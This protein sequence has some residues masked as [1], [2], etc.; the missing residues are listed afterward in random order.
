MTINN[1]LSLTEAKIS[2][3]KLCLFI[4]TVLSFVINFL[5]I[6][7][8][9]RGGLGF[10]YLVLPLIICLI[11]GAFV[12]AATFTN[13]KFSYSALYTTVFSVIFGITTLISALVFLN[14]GKGTAI[15][16][17]AFILW[18]I[19]AAFSITAIIISAHRAGKSYGAVK[20]VVSIAVLSVCIIAYSV[21]LFSNGFFGQGNEK[22]QRPIS[23]VYDSDKE[24]YVATEIMSGRGKTAVVPAT[25]NGI[26]VGAID[27]NLFIDSKIKSVSLMTGP[28]VV[29]TNTEVLS[30][31]VPDID[32]FVSKEHISTYA[33]TLYSLVNNTGKECQGICA[34]ASKLVPS[35]IA[36]NEIYV[37][38]SYSP[39]SILCSGGEYIPVW[40]GH[41]NDVFSFDYV[42]GCDYLMYADVQNESY[43][44]RIYNSNLFN[45]GNVL[46]TVALPSGAPIVG[47]T[48]TESVKAVEINFEKVFRINVLEDNDGL[49]E[50]SDSFKHLNSASDRYRYV[51]RST[52]DS[53]LT[54]VA[55]RAGFTLGWEYNARGFQ[56]LASI[57]TD[58]VEEYSLQPKWALNAPELTS[59]KTNTG[60]ASYVYGDSLAFTVNAAKPLENSTLEYV[61]Y[62]DNQQIYTSR[63]YS[64][65][66]M[67]MDDKGVYRLEIIAKAPSVTTLTS[68]TIQEIN[69]TVDKKT[70]NI[71]WLGFDGGNNFTKTYDAVDSVIDISYN[72]DELVLSDDIISYRFNYSSLKNAGAYSVAV[73][74]T[75]DAA[76]KYKVSQP[77]KTY[78][79]SKREVD[80]EWSTN[81]IY[82][83]ASAQA[84]AV[85]ITSG[86]MAGDNLTAV[87]SSTGCINA[88]EYTTNASLQGESK[89][90]YVLK[91]SQ[92]VHKYTILPSPLY[93]NWSNV[94]QTYQGKSLAPTAT[95]VG[96]HGSDTVAGLGI[97][98]N[99]AKTAGI[100]QITATITNKNYVI[101][102]GDEKV[103]FEILPASLSITFSKTTAVYTSGVL[104]PSYTVASGI[105]AGDTLAGLGLSIEGK[106]NVGV[107]DLT[108]TLTN[109]NYQ[110]SNPTVE[111]TI[112]P[113]TIKVVWN[114]NKSLTYNGQAQYL[115]ISSTTGIYT[116]DRSSVTVK[117]NADTSAN[118][119][120]GKYTAYAYIDDNSG[121]GNYVLDT[122]TSEQEYSIVQATLQ[123][124]WT[125]LIF[126]YDK[127]AK[128]PTATLLTSPFGDDIV[129]VTVSGAKI[130][131]GKD[132]VATATVDNPNYKLANAT[133]KFTINPKEIDVSWSELTFTYDGQTH[134]PQATLASTLYSG[135]TTTITVSGAQK[136]AGTNHVATAT[137]SNTNYKVSTATATQTFVINPRE[138]TVS[139]SNTTLT[140]NGSNQ[141]PTATA[142]GGLI[143]G[144]KV[145]FTYTGSQK[146]AGTG[147]TA[148]AKSAN[149]NYVVV[150]NA[151]QSYSISP[152]TVTV[153]WSNLKKTYTG[154][155]LSPTATLSGVA[156]GDSVP[157]TIL[158]GGSI[159]GQTAVG[160]YTAQ[161]TINNTNYVLDYS[162]A[163]ATFEIAA[164]QSGK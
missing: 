78:E 74:L 49:Y 37:T 36:D 39:E 76:T 87:A 5:M 100:H 113:A 72:R 81:P 120:C 41:E 45:G 80:I 119:S 54:K 23:F 150:T 157:V 53:M 35:D 9:A 158:V 90:N 10:G 47:Q 133:A 121:F 71:N 132:Y 17:V 110:I 77:T 160:K 153:N 155:A 123:L 43:L 128:L 107:Y 96:L 136:N 13:F 25:F 106:T 137:S 163:T 118:V 135:D 48:M 85:T 55:S 94:S 109:T 147:Y 144:D 102:S 101:N 67:M 52:A 143:S 88:G 117:V 14:I 60:K 1:K 146:N 16:I 116:A 141:H 108:L 95:P 131:A 12:A 56:S 50:I 2:N 46:K 24:Y 30:A 3:H 40:I 142:A 59:F 79:I 70:L 31:G 83:N 105:C 152:K 19:S 28:S 61:W 104:K 129:N 33:T 159:T 7:T 99:T 8:I 26:K 22:L 57:L 51:T 6:I 75:E 115:G 32:V 161:A 69:I 11:D 148:T 29:F 130:D 62:K 92:T 68:K 20:A 154:K 122:A 42:S 84:P 125:N 139:W 65:D 34:L 58:S 4:S 127:T 89:A 164:A 140:Y 44:S 134:A 15:T 145:T 114:T 38:F 91:S 21:S 124:T 149:A 151:T 86:I 27:C 63:D 111:F 18:I 103:D 64:N 138:L 162:T 156:S 93:I 112:T 97:K 66:K 73:T 82:Y 126:T 98:V